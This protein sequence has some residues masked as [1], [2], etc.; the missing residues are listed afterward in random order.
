MVAV[1]PNGATAVTY[2]DDVTA[3]AVARA[4]AI[5]ERG[6][7]RID[8]AIRMKAIGLTPEYIGAMQVAVPSLSRLDF[9]DFAGVQ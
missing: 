1:A 3:A 7:A 8:K 5:R 4:D 6:D 9:D 2:V